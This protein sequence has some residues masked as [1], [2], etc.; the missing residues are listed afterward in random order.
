MV[1]APQPQPPMLM[2]V[3]N[4]W[5]Y[6]KYYKAVLRDYSYYA[7]GITSIHAILYK[8]NNN[9]IVTIAQRS[10]DQQQL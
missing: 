4:T 6:P 7:I 10:E 5:S 8:C 1:T 9:M 2:I 3:H